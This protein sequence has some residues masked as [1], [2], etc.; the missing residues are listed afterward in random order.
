MDKSMD[1]KRNFYKK[2]P[3][4]VGFAAKA[5]LLQN[6]YLIENELQGEGWTLLDLEYAK[7]TGKNFLTERIFKLVKKE[8]LNRDEN[9]KEVLNGD[10]KGRVIMQPRIWENLLSSQPL[11]FNLFG[12]LVDN[13]GLATRVF[14]DLF[15]DRKVKNIQG[16]QV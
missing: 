16:D 5:R 12:E 11:A 2:H 10:E 14:Q 13:L 7:K 8:V 4:R 3:D 15:P 1:A 6:T 9:G